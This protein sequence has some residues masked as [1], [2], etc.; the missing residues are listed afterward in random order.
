M[1]ESTTYISIAENDY[2]Y[3]KRDI[4]EGRV[5]NLVAFN[6]QGVC[7]KFLK[8]IIVYYGLEEAC[9]QKELSSHS[10]RKLVNF[11]RKNI[12]EVKLNWRKVLQADGFYFN[13]RYPGDD[14]FDVTKEDIEMCWEAATEVRSYV[15][16]LKDKPLK[17]LETKA[18]IDFLKEQQEGVEE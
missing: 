2:Q 12:P 15:I 16:T 14:Y 10:I 17:K 3:L 18:V 13:T 7:E 4:Q 9:T 1:G 11:I 6:T 5:A 8:G